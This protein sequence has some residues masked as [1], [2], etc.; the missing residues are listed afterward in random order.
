VRQGVFANTRAG[1]E[2]CVWRIGPKMGRRS[3]ADPTSPHPGRAA[4]DGVCAGRDAPGSGL[5]ARS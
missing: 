1:D 4:P 2:T 3:A 5:R